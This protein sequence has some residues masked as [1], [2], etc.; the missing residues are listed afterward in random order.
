MNQLFVT[1]RC[2][3]CGRANQFPIDAL[4]RRSSCHHCS[5]V[6]AVRDKDS[7]LAGDS[8]SIAWWLRFTESGSRMSP[9]FE[10]PEKTLPR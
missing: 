2:P 1:S 10:L 4:G 9:Q 7:F 5:R 6:M 8:D 3:G